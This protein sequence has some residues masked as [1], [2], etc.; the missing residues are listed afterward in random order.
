ML[1]SQLLLTEWGDLSM[2]AHNGSRKSKR[3][4]TMRRDHGSRMWSNVRRIHY[5]VL[6]LLTLHLTS[7]FLFSI[8]WGQ[9][10]NTLQFLDEGVRPCKNNCVSLLHVIL[11]KMPKY[12]IWSQSLSECTIS[13][14]G[15]SDCALNACWMKLKAKSGYQL[16]SS[17]CT[18]HMFWKHCFTSILLIVVCNGC[19]K[20]DILWFSLFSVNVRCSY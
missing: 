17:I 1:F 9:Q 16:A 13:N 12:K 5:L 7:T 11:C 3:A 2:R 15:M 10:Y 20:E 4:R 8:S 19:I 18:A 14:W 6:I